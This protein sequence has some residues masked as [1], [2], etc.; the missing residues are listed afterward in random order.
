VIPAAP[1]WLI[2]AGATLLAAAILAV[3][4]QRLLAEVSG[5]PRSWRGSVWLG[6]AAAAAGL[7]AVAAA[8]ALGAEAEAWRWGALAATLCAL[9]IVDARHLVIP[10]LYVLALLALAIGWV[11]WLPAIVG[12]ALG[13]GLLW[14]ARLLFLRFRQVEALGLGDVKLMV[15]LG[16]LAGAEGVLWII[17]AGSLIGVVLVLARGRSASGALRLAP[18]GACAAPPALVVMALGRLGA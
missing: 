3:A 16:A 18:L 14:I 15:A 4:P 13:G 12:A 11:G 8:T 17:M 5:R 2:G 6:A 9:T 1:G 7:A 10:D